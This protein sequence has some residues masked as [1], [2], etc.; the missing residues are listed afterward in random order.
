VTITEEDASRGEAEVT[1]ILGLCFRI[2]QVDDQGT[3]VPYSEISYMPALFASETAG[4]EKWAV[5]H[6]IKT[7]ARGSARF[8]HPELFRLF[9]LPGCSLTIEP[10]T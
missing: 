4:D 1:M 10:D 6:G 8:F 2:T 5:A 9:P 7:D 3:P